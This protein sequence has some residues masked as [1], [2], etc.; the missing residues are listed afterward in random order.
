MLVKK[1]IQEKNN[2]GNGS[3]IKRTNKRLTNLLLEAIERSR[4]NRTFNWRI[5]N[6]KLLLKMKRE[7]I[8]MNPWVI[9]KFRKD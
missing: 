2:E 1:P 6:I 4:L 8:I 9:Q 3:I 7:F 5:E